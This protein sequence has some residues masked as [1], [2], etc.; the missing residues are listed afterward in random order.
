M[1][2]YSAS[3]FLNRWYPPSTSP[4]VWPGRLGVGLMSEARTGKAGRVLRCDPHPSRKGDPRTFL[5]HT[6]VRNS[7]VIRPVV[8]PSHLQQAES[9][10][11]D[12]NQRR[13]T[14]IWIACARPPSSSPLG[15]YGGA[16]ALARRSLGPLRQQV[17]RREK[18]ARECGTLG[19]RL[20]ARSAADPRGCAAAQ[21][22]E[23]DSPLH[24]VGV[25]PRQ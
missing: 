24:P 22:A 1:L 19:R 3:F 18:S 7:Y 13:K 8:L 11:R 10:P 4:D 21:V 2:E 9:R 20:L 17:T 25:F 16:C 12:R 5:G 15:S 23:R 14:A 6:F